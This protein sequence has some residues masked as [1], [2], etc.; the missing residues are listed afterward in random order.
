MYIVL[1]T[2]ATTFGMI[3]GSYE[4]WLTLSTGESRATGTIML[5]AVS[6]LIGVQLLLN[7][8]LYDV[9]LG[10]KTFREFGTRSKEHATFLTVRERAS[11][12]R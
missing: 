11:H 8:L 1:G 9:Q 6:L 3:F 12:A 7:A 5:V 2:L 4:W 10:P